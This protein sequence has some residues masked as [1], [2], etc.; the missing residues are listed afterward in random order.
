ME[1]NAFEY[2]NACNNVNIIAKI[3]HPITPFVLSN[4]LLSHKAE[5]PHVTYAPDDNKITVLTNGIPNGFGGNIPSG[6]HKPNSSTLGT[7][8][9]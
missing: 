3:I 1:K 5:C 8:A 9:Q 4:L 2:S 6:G 7:H